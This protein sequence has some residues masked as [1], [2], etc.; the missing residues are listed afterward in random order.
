MFSPDH[1]SRDESETE[2]A[3][4][5]A[6]SASAKSPRH[7]WADSGR[8][9]RTGLIGGLALVVG[10]SSVAYAIWTSPNNATGVI[11][12]LSEQAD[13][14]NPRVQSLEQENAELMAKI[15]G[16]REQI[17]T[18][19]SALKAKYTAPTQPKATEARAAPK[20]VTAPRSTPT[21]KQSTPVKQPSV[22]PAAAPIT[23][24]S[25]AE[26][27]NPARRYTGIYTEQ[28]PFNWSTY[29][30]VAAKAGIEPSMV[31][32]FS[33]WDEP[34]RANGVTR[35]W[36]QGRL[37]MLTW[38]SRPIKAGNNVIEEPDYSL[39]RILGDE[40]NGVPGAYDEYLRQYA[41]D[42]VATGLPL[43]IRL[44]HEMNG[45]WYPWA[46]STGSGASINGNRPGDY[47]AM[48]RHVHDIFE[49]EGAGDLVIWVWSPNIINNL[50]ASHQTPQFLASLYPG[51]EYVDW[52]GL[53]GYLRPAYKPDNTFTFG[54][55][56][57]RSLDQLRTVAPGK[58]ILLA[59]VGASETGGHK[60]AWVKS[61]FDALGESK[62][63]DIIGLA[64][65][66]LAVSTYTEGVLGTNDWRMDSRAET[67]AAF[68]EGFARPELNLDTGP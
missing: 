65:F 68:R 6:V 15:A 13:D 50:P 28:A 11:A 60:P 25:I 26:L 41:R 23:A 48:W 1:S 40:A 63:Q 67:L 31:G 57:D 19:D 61:M 47:A 3:A 20:S 18:R 14:L 62:N 52:V 34:F 56:F 32:Y 51:D 27:L 59:E 8:A 21:P 58:P 2:V 12:S 4:A 33:G 55:T 37:P 5:P 46:E 44:D 16:L 45:V 54:Y 49:Q 10:L 17:A 38:E 42:V 64:W 24:P 22:T 7:W 9:V 43:A 39:P 36:S 66:D 29:D 35:A 53:S 30:D